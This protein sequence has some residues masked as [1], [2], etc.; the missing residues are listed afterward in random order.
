MTKLALGTAQFGQEYGISNFSG[1]IKRSEVLEILK[2]A[3]EQKIDLIDTAI[4]YGE[5]ENNLGD[6]GVS[7]FNVVTKLPS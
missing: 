4:T 3:Q 5:S 7:N 2:S 6:I 1:P